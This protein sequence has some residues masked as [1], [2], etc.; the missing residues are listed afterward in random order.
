MLLWAPI[1]YPSV[2]FFP[3][4]GLLSCFART[5]D[6][7]PQPLP[8]SVLSTSRCYAPFKILLQ[9][10]SHFEQ[11]RLVR[12]WNVVF[13]F[14]RHLVTIPS[15]PPLMRV[16]VNLVLSLLLLFFPLLNLGTMIVLATNTLFQWFSSYVFSTK[17]VFLRPYTSPPYF[18][19]SKTSVFLFP[20][21]SASLQVKSRI[22]A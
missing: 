5:T 17:R 21:F 11:P 3:H 9:H 13:V 18:P 22:S 19:T 20:W 2:R 1:L 16:N 12:R 15:P 7:R 10:S 14:F 8:S 6:P 4:K